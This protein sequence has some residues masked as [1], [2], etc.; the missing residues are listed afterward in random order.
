LTLNT[1]GIGNHCQGPELQ[2]TITVQG[3]AP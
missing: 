2:G 1:I 3:T